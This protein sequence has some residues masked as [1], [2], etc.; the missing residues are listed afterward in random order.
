MIPYLPR[1]A[2]KV[3]SYLR[4]PPKY[5]T[6]RL[7]GRLHTTL[8]NTTHTKIVV[9]PFLPFERLFDPQILDSISFSLS[10]ARCF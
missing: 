9:P 7:D 2:S 6:D 10:F 3:L 5:G 4:C 8:A 1:M